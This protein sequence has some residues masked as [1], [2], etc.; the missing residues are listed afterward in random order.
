M[1]ETEG[2]ATIATVAAFVVV[3]I[4]IAPFVD[5]GVFLHTWVLVDS[6]FI[7]DFTNKSVDLVAA[8][9]LQHL[10]LVEVGGGPFVAV[11]KGTSV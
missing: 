10:L 6:R 5:I 11:T 1:V 3:T 9:V 2:V 4:D 8:T 7:V